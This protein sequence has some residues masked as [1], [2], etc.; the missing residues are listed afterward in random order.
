MTATNEKFID[1]NINFIVM[2]Y[3]SNRISEASDR[4]ERVNFEFSHYYWIVIELSPTRNLPP[5]VI[6]PFVYEETNYKNIKKTYKESYLRENAII[7]PEQPQPHLRISI[8]TYPKGAIIVTIIDE[9][10]SNNNSNNNS[11]SNSSSNSNNRHVYQTNTEDLISMLSVNT[12]HVQ[13]GSLSFG[14]TNLIRELIDMRKTH[15]DENGPAWLTDID[16][17]KPKKRQTIIQSVRN[18]IIFTKEKIVHAIAQYE[19]KK[20]SNSN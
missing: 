18:T 20:S 15:A 2:H 16:P 5:E 17:P 14:I 4:H 6:L 7:S 8:E 9:K 13:I 11:N 12:K 19:N 1:K 10:N 3:T